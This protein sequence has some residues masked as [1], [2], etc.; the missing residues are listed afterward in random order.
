MPLC[1]KS[2][3]VIFRKNHGKDL[4]HQNLYIVIPDKPNIE[5]LI[6]MKTKL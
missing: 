5:I 4:N 1:A 2:L 3:Q 6:A